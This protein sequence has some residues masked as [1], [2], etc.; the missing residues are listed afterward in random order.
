M[1]ARWIGMA[2]LVLLCGALPAAAQTIRAVTETGETV[3]LHPDGTWEYAPE[4]EA[5]APVTHFR[6]ARWGMTRDEVIASEGRQPD[7][8]GQN[9]LAYLTQVEGLDAVAVY[10]FT[11]GRLTAAVY[12]IDTSYISAANAV[13]HYARLKEWLSSVYGEPAVDRDVWATSL[14]RGLIS[15]GL[16]VE[17]GLLSK[18]AEWT[19]E[20]T[21]V[22]LSL[23]GRAFGVDLL[24]QYESR[25]Q[26]E[27]PAPEA[28][29][30]DGRWI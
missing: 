11:E 19:T 24:V 28:P 14:M 10:V 21:A 26:L 6:N 15:E 1:K 7:Q 25:V 16:A 4:E 23:S 13:R 9:T 29:E 2:L 3:L 17:M 30:P 22:R 18:V 12:A 20:H 5:Q 27:E 8:T